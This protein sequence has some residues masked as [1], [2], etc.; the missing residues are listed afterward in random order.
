MVITILII[1]II[2]LWKKKKREN[3]T[4]LRKHNEEMLSAEYSSESDTKK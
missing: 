3:I 1:T 4:K 2:A